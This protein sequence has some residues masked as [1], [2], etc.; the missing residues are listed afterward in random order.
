MLN[1][2]DKKNWQQVKKFNYEARGF[3]I[4]NSTVIN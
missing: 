3:M 2:H 1:Q 4:F